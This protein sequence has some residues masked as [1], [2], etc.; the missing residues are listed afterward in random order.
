M[1]LMIDTM[2]HRV[3]YGKELL[4]GEG[5]AI[6]YYIQTGSR[7]PRRG[8]VGLSSDDIEKFEILGYVMSG[9][10]HKRMNAVR[11][12]KEQQI[13]DAEQKKA[14]MIFNYEQKIK[15]EKQIV[16]ELQK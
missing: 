4:P 11:Q 6:A 9:S 5:A 7:I 1:P 14:L 12:R 10:K 15:R 13:F 2:N 3:N 8:E 16:D